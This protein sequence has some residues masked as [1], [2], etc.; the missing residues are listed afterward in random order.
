MKKMRFLIVIGFL[1][2]FMLTLMPKVDAEALMHSIG[3]NSFYTYKMEGFPTQ[4][5]S[6]S[7]QSRFLALA[8]TMYFPSKF[9]TNR[10]DDISALEESIRY[11]IE[12]FA[13]RDQ[14]KKNGEIKENDK[15]S[16]DHCDWHKAIETLIDEKKY[17]LEEYEYHNKYEVLQKI[18]EINDCFQVAGI[19]IEKIEWNSKTETYTGGHVISV[20]GVTVDNRLQIFNSWEKKGSQSTNT[21]YYTEIPCDKIV[22]K[23]FDG[24][25]RVYSIQPR[26]G[27]IKPCSTTAT[28][29]DLSPHIPDATGTHSDASSP[30][31]LEPPKGPGNL[32]Q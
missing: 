1:F 2:V 16:V 21:G 15:I 6:Q 28:K 13:I 18:K 23:K 29:I 22:Y 12:Y 26:M 19:S 30:P 25:Y 11:L 5:N 3:G 20:I 10:I 17:M 24:R 14:L 27:P 9:P 31:G 7:C 32:T 8:L 4:I